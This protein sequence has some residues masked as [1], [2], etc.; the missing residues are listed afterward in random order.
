MLALVSTIGLR[1]LRE[2]AGELVRRAEVGE[3]CV[4]TV[5]GRE[6]ARLGPVRRRQWRRAADIAPIFAGPPDPDWTADRA[7][8]GYTMQSPRSGPSYG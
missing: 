1:E 5:N 2:R 7:L 4:V 3:I 8:L 6:V